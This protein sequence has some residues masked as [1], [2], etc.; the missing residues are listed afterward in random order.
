DDVT[1][2]TLAVGYTI[3]GGSQQTMDLGGNTLSVDSLAI[4]TN[5]A[6]LLRLNLGTG[7]T[8]NRG[9]LTTASGRDLVLTAE[10]SNWTTTETIAVNAAVT[11]NTGVSNPGIVNLVL[12]GTTG[13]IGL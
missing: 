3:G 8:S 5:V 13:V 12:G 7:T 1:I 10:A 6:A 2:G 4:G 11:D 9:F